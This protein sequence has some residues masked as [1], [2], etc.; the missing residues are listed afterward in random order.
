MSRRVYLYSPINY[1][2]VLKVFQ[3]EEKLLML[4]PYS[5][6]ISVAFGA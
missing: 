5:Q 4:D 2:T 6:R 1:F 3:L